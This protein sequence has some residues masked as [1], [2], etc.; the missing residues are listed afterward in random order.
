MR[1]RGKKSIHA[2]RYHGL[3]TRFTNGGHY[4]FFF[5]KKGIGAITILG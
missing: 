1:R 3:P 5:G 4:I 2:S